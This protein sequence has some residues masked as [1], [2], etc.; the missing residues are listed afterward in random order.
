VQELKGVLNMFFLGFVSCLLIDSYGYKEF[1][2]KKCEGQ[3]RGA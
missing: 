3:P 1:H 2:E